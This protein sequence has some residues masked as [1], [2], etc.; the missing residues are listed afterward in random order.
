MSIKKKAFFHQ[1]S[2]RKAWK[3]C[4]FPNYFLKLSQPDFFFV[5][6]QKKRYLRFFKFCGQW[7]NVK[8]EGGLMAEGLPSVL[9]FKETIYWK[10]LWKYLK[11]RYFRGKHDKNEMPRA[12]QK[13]S[14]K[15]LKKSFFMYWMTII[16]I[17]FN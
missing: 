11:W 2:K 15:I 8:W 17:F 6:R 9:K 7:R 3:K 1:K 16:D 4:F 13:L 10:V 5:V 12:K 14:S